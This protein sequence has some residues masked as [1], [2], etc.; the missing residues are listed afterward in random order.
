MNDTIHTHKQELQIRIE[1]L[2]ESLSK[3][4]GKLRKE[5]EDDQHAAIDNLE[6]YLE[7]VDHKYVNLRDFWLIMVDEFRGL[8]DDLANDKKGK[9]G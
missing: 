8:F 4:K 3:L 9:R 5:E 6:I 2:E 1:E 7:E